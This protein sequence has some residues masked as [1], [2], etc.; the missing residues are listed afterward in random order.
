MRLDL[1]R[2]CKVQHQFAAVQ[3]QDMLK[4]FALMTSVAEGYRVD[5]SLSYRFCKVKMGQD[6]TF[7][8][9]QLTPSE[10][11]DKMIFREPETMLQKIGRIGNYTV[12]C[13]SSFAWGLLG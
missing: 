6:V 3:D 12:D 4:F 2:E 11:V 10:L 7:V 8:D 13:S 5:S 1:D 9:L